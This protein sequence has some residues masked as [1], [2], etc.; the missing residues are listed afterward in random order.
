[1]LLAVKPDIVKPVVA[2]RA[3]GGEAIMLEAQCMSSVIHKR[4]GLR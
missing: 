4:R 1:M 2:V 3:L